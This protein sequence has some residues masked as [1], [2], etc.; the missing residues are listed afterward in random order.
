MEINLT[1]PALLFSTLSLIMLAYTNRFLALANRIRA[2]HSKY[3]ESRDRI[4]REQIENLRFRVVLVRNM[5]AMAILSLT[6]TVVCMFLLFA[7]WTFAGKVI[8]ALS[9]VCLLISLLISLREIMV[10][11]RALNLQLKDLE[12]PDDEPQRMG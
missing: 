3:L 5:Q 7:G 1:T 8:F 11:C 2:L 9:L 4:I 12:N 6:L 10:S